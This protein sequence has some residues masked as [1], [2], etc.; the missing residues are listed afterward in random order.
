MDRTEV[1]SDK[2][3]KDLKEFA[4]KFVEGFGFAWRLSFVLVEGSL[5]EDR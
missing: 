5:L 4:E 2:Q 1:S 3:V